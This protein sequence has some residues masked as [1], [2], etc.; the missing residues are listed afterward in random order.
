M[1]EDKKICSIQ[2][3]NAIIIIL[4]STILVIVTKSGLDILQV[5]IYQDVTQL[6]S[7]LALAAQ[8]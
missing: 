4:A 2:K 5:R 3:L 7:R 8:G 1:T 6:G